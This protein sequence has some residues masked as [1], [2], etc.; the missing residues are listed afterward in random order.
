[1]TVSEVITSWRIARS[2]PNW[3]A[4][5]LSGNGSAKNPGRWNSVNQ[6]IV[7][8]ARSISLACLETLV[9]FVGDDEL[10][11]NYQLI[12]IA[13]PSHHWQQR[14]IF[15]KQMISNWNQ[16]PTSGKSIDDSRA[17]SR[18]WGSAWLSSVDTLIAE[19]P[20]VIVPEE[21]NLLINPLH[22]ANKEVVAEI[23]RP[24][25]YDGRLLRSTQPPAIKVY[26]PKTVQ[27][28]DKVHLEMVPIPAGKF[29][30]GS[31]DDEPDRQTNESPQHLVRL[32]RFY[33]ARTPITQAQW[34]AVAT[35]S[36]EDG[37][38]LWERV[39]NPDPSYFRDDQSDND[40]D[41]RPV[42]NVSWLDAQEFC[43]RL[44]Q[45]T[46]EIY[47]LPTEAQWEYACRAGTTSAFAFGT[48]LNNEQ[49]NVY[50]FETSKVDKYNSNRYGLQ[51]MH[52]NVWE[53]CDDHWHDDYLGAPT[54]GDSWI[55]PHADEVKPRCMR[56]GSWKDTHIK[57]R[58]AYR[59]YWPPFYLD[60]NV[61]FRVCSTTLSS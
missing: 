6:R 39:L 45:R 7:Y 53:W 54:N 34:R 17:A 4:N 44:R 35:W 3:A 19:V 55:N 22:P 29:W 49:A 24:W 23:V 43:R 9:R 59:D 14:K 15:P 56:G 1:V 25:V 11:L 27:L 48:T 42:E 8:S 40:D 41:R 47:T 37:A 33:L 13:I 2:G 57:C 50:S 30:M 26:S 61:G 31:A 58:S 20:S 46:G 21:A 12:R 36:P 60:K 28:K 5:D 38:P 51:D 32:P 18:E 16:H 52:G 10:P